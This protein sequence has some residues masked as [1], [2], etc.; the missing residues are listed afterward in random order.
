[1]TYVV[2]E[3]CSGEV[4]AARSSACR[5]FVTLGETVLTMSFTY[6]RNRV[7]KMTLPCGT[8][9]LSSLSAKRSIK[10]HSGRSVVEK[11]V[12]LTLKLL[13]SIFSTAVLFFH[14]Q[15]NAFE[16]SKKTASSFRFS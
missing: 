6:R 8:P 5:E 10:L 13:L 2:V 14:T 4:H 9:S 12:H 3:V 7:G 1:M 15:S 16:R 11:A